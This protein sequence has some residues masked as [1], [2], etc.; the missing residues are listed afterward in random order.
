MNTKIKEFIKILNFYKIEHSVRTTKNGTFISEKNT[1]QKN[2]KSC[3]FSNKEKI[4]DEMI[5]IYKVEFL[6]SNSQHRNSSNTSTN[7]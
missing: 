7:D 5:L 2:R 3:F 4:T 1:A 6:L